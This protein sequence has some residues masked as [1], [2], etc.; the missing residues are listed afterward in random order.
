MIIKYRRLS[1]TGH[2]FDRTTGQ[3]KIIEKLDQSPS[4]PSSSQFI[5]FAEIIQI[6]SNIHIG[7]H[8]NKGDIIGHNDQSPGIEVGWGQ[9]PTEGFLCPIGIPTPCGT[10]FNSWVQGL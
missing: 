5:Y 7:V 8:V 10:S 3:A 9:S 6:N 1:P 2:H 4:A